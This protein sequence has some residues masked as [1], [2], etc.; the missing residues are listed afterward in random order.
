MLEFFAALFLMLAGAR[1]L[2]EGARRVN[3]PALV[4]ELIAG[5]ILG[6][7]ALNLVTA[8]PDLAA[9]TN[10]SLFLIMFLTGLNLST[11]D[12]ADV[13][14]K[15]AVMAIPAFTI[16]FALGVV[17]ASAL[18]VGLQQSLGLGLALSI[19][20]V[21]VNSM[22]MMDL[23]ILKTKLGNS[24]I[25]VGVIED[26]MALII[27]G[28]ILQLPAGGSAA[29]IDY[30]SVALSLVKVGIFVG[31]VLYADRWMREHP[32][33]VEAFA[34]KLGPR[35]L[36]RESGLAFILVFG[37][38]VSLL[39]EAMGLHFIIGTYFAGLL[40]SQAFSQKWLARGLD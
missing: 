29:S 17:G 23:G 10:V 27:L 12:L 21:P 30:G 28:V 31:A 35:L 20:A 2:G 39:A 14:W 26:Q 13:G 18:G 34:M 22:I 19:T 9:V 8:T 6:V 16:P 32:G 4:G 38:G 25:T 36:A 3:Q 15:A 40:V 11:E 24:V 7:S 37:I 33:R 1:L 5:T